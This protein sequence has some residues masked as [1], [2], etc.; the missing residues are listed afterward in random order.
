MSINRGMDNKGEVHIY[1]EI[2]LNRKKERM[3]FATTRMD[4]DCHTY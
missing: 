4:P 2:L 3:T 1:N